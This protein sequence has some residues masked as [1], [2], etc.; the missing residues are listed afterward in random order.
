[1]RLID[2]ASV[3]VI[4]I[5]GGLI[6]LA[7]YLH[8]PSLSHIAIGIFG[9]FGVW[10]GADTFMARSVCGTACTAAAKTIRARQP[11]CWERSFSCLGR[12]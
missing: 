4:V 2:K 10:L 8:L 5:A 11:A 6:Y 1:M 9:L 12:G 3:P 7:E